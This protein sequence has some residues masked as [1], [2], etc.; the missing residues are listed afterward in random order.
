VSLAALRT[1]IAAAGLLAFTQTHAPAQQRFYSPAERTLV[2]DGGIV[3][4][5]AVGP[6]DVYGATDF[7]IVVHDAV[8][9][10]WKTPLP[11]PIE[12]LA[13]RPSALAFD[14]AAGVLWLGTAAGDIF[15]TS[16]GFDRWDRVAGARGR[17]DAI[18][19]WPQ[20]G[21]VYI[22]AGG[23]WLRIPG[24]TFFADRVPVNALP[25]AVEAEATRLPDDPWFRAARGTIGLD[26][27]NRRW[28]LTDVAGGRQPGEFWIATD[29]G[30]IIRFDTRS[31]RQAWLRYGLAGTGAGS[32]AMLDGTV[33]VGTDGRDVRGGVAWTDPDLATW[34]QQFRDD[35][36]PAGFVAEIV[37]FAGAV[38]FAAQDGLFR[39]EGVPEP[40][41]RGDWSRS[42]SADGLASDRVRSLAV[43]R[44]SLWA[45]TDRGLTAFDTTGRAI[46]S[47]LF[48]GQRVSR[49]ATRADTLFV[50]T[51]RGLQSLVVGS[52]AAA[53]TARPSPAGRSPAL[54]GRV[55]DVV[56]DDSLMFAITADG[57][58]DVSGEETPV[59]DAV[60]DR[61]G[62]PFRLALRDGHLWVAG[63]RGIARRD[64]QSHIWQAFTVPEDVHAGPVVDVLPVGDFVWAATPA[65]AV[66]LRWR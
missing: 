40:G 7:G 55:V 54:R 62:P 44:G 39:L 22:L 10:R 51:D 4:A 36:A 47:P 42:T 33:W 20:D 29:G 52:P 64:P 38:W 61:V 14:P 2:G 3:H 60:L 41:G 17:V 16:P 53:A 37:T 50:A 12:M 25:P 1:A 5:V 6:F 48:T 43:A 13:T 32:I 9:E 15:S 19:A 46:R 11:L 8:R 23:E 18:V 57:I 63:P 49:M 56:A 26:P 34:G 27:R 28:D 45:G 31:V 59:R 30:G 35:G 66:R 21:S 65:G 58:I 24:G